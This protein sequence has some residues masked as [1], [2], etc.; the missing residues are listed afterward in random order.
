MIQIKTALLSVTDK[1]GLGELALELQQQGVRLVAS[2]GTGEFLQ[3]MGV[4]FTPLA[5][6]SGYNQ[7][8]DGRCKSLSINVMGGLLFDREKHAEEAKKLGVTPIDL[9]VCNLYDF[10]SAWQS[11]KAQDQLVEQIDI[12]GVA[13]LRASAKNCRFVVSLSSPADYPLLI[14]EMR[15]NAGSVSRDFAKKLA[16]KSFV[17]C[18]EYD[19]LVALGFGGQSLRYGENP[20]QKAWSYDFA[21]FG[22]FGLKKLQGKELS[23]NNFLDIK[24]GLDCLQGLQ[25]NGCVV[26]KHGNPCGVCVSKIDTDGL[27]QSAWAGDSVSAFGSIIAFSFAVGV[28]DLAFLDL[29]EKGKAKFVEVVVAPQFTEGTLEYLAQKKNLRACSYEPKKAGRS[30]AFRQL[31]SL[32]IAQE[33]DTAGAEK[34]EVAVGQSE[35]L[36]TELVH[37]GTKVVQALSSNAVT[38]VYRDSSQRLR[39][40]SMGCGQPNRLDAIELAMRKLERSKAAGDF[41]GQAKDCYLVSDAFLPFADNVQAV[42]NSGVRTIVQPGG[43][44]RD[45]QV[46][47]A[48]KELAVR[49]VFT[50]VRHFR[51]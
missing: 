48:C 23:Y 50:G 31:D 11:G 25:G 26:I 32:L 35:N 5:E 8:F 3:K 14:A 15:A 17:A 38:L 9:V 6:L 51:H 39:Q 36:D 24:A 42:A 10:S 19:R 46:L 41:C 33:Q 7:A 34:L 29:Q 28:A 20:H 37:F 22:F 1:S 2:K 49:M 40:V 4:K 43:S 16:A 44:I 45:K 47:A 12:G 27:L 13:L 18:S 30:L 21:D